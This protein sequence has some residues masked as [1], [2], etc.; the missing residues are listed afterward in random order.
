MTLDQMVEL[1]WRRIQEGADHPEELRGRVSFDDAYR[2]QF[3]LIERYGGAGEQQAGWK[4]GLTSKAMQAQLG[5]PQPVFGFLL[6][7]GHRSTGTVFDY[8]SLTRPGFENE[9]CLTVGTTLTGPGVTLEQARRAIS[10]VAPALEII[11]RRGGSRADLGLALADNAQQKAFVTGVPMPL[12]TVDL[13]KVTLELSVNGVAQERA[14]ACIIH[15]CRDR[16][17]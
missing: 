9:L 8:T 11:E 2:I 17:S 16:V 6:Q 5:I 3:G 13:A 7:S 1:M 14:L 12:G 4:V 10:Y 15:E